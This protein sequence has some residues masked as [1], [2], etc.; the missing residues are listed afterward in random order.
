MLE[1]IHRHSGGVAVQCADG[2]GRN[3]GEF[4]QALMPLRSFEPKT[5]TET[6]LSETAVEWSCS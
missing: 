3:G 2:R 5:E 4:L 6:D 1:E